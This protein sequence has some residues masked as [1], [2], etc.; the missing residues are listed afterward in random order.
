MFVRENTALKL[1]WSRECC[2]SGGFN[3][4]AEA[5]ADF[6]KVGM[7]EVQFAL[8]VSERDRERSG[9]CNY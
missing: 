5:G 3:Y 4:L 8:P 6:V 9:Y 2:G 1:K 7:A